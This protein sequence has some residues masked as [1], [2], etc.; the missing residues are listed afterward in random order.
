MS[1]AGIHKKIPKVQFEKELRIERKEGDQGKKMVFFFLLP[2]SFFLPSA[3][4]LSFSFS[5][6]FLLRET[7]W[8]RHVCALDIL[9]SVVREGAENILPAFGLKGQ[10]LNKR[11]NLV[12]L[13]RE[14][15]VC[16]F[17]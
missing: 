1:I 16:L 5:F 9:S 12:Q 7:E 3:F 8:W 2:S 10:S 6:S 15:F 17:F 4:I 11:G 14:V 13:K